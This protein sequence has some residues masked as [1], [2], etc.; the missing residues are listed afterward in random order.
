MIEIKIMH[1]V[2]V[3][4]GKNANRATSDPKAAL[5][6]ARDVTQVMRAVTQ[7]S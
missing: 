4:Q 6:S 5:F 1:L 3:G 7:A 2:A